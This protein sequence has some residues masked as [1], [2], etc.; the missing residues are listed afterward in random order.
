MIGYS[1]LMLTAKYKIFSYYYERDLL[2]TIQF[3]FTARNPIKSFNNNNNDDNT[4]NNNDNNVSNFLSSFTNFC[5]FQV[6]C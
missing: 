6:L 2:K 4:N 1:S 3:K 5:D